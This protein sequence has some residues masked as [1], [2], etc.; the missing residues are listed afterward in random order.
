MKV[1]EKVESQE[2][3][4]SLRNISKTFTVQNKPLQSIKDRI[5]SFYKSSETRSFKGLKDINLEIFKGE[6]VGFVGHNGSGKSTI[7]KIMSGAYVPDKGGE[8]VRNGTSLLMNLGV[9]FSHELTARENIYVNGST[10]GL[11]ISQID[12]IFDKI[13]AFAELEEFVDTKI[14]Y[15]S[16]GM[17]QRLAFSVAINA[18]ADI[19]FL[20]EVFAVGDKTFRQ[21]ATSMLE[22]NWMKDR[23][24]ILVSH[25]RGM[26]KKY[27]N[28]VG[29]MNK[30][31]L[32]FFGD[33]EEALAL[34]DSL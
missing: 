1:E 15:F 4:I 10:L 26:I 20:D 23:T 7:T 34:Y 21:K 11:R 28:K 27:C 9:G 19:I 25:S 8:V 30:G 6:R 3:A 5:F 22:D 33:T 14:K 32:K 24:V 16:S 17:T 2:I 18:K 31:E 13:I 29:V 12:E